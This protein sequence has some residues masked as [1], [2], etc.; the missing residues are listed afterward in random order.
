MATRLVHIVT[1]RLL[2]V[3]EAFGHMDPAHLA[4]LLQPLVEA[5]LL[6]EPHGALIVKLLRPVL[7][8]LLTRVLANLQLE[9]ED[10]LDLKAV[11]LEAFV[12]DKVV[13]VELFQK[14]T[15]GTWGGLRCFLTLLR[16]DINPPLPP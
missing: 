11:V 13:L 12:R 2:T 7:P 5:E 8:A 15:R 10:L 6:K 4:A 14:V 1:E 3:E 16:C 9:I